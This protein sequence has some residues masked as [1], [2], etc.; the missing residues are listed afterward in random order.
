MGSHQIERIMKPED[1]SF[2][3]FTE[4]SNPYI[5]LITNNTNKKLPTKKNILIFII[6]TFFF[7]KI[8]LIL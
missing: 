2:E 7:V 4:L 5:N 6:K 8:F 3:K 1:T